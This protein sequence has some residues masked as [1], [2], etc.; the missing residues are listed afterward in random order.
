[1]VSGTMSALQDVI[2]EARNHAIADALR[3]AKERGQELTRDELDRIVKEAVDK[4]VDEFLAEQ[5]MH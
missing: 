1:M 3:A 4:A 5:E 2:D